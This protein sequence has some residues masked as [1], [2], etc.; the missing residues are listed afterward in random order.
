MQGILKHISF[1]LA[2]V[3]LAGLVCQTSAVLHFYLNRDS[4]AI[5]CENKDKPEMK[6][7]GKC[8]LEKKLVAQNPSEKNKTTSIPALQ[9]WLYAVEEM[10]PLKLIT[11]QILSADNFSIRH[12]CSNYCL[13]CAVAPPE[14][15]T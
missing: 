6:C 7:H 15:N 9:F 2:V 8:Q 10:V 14:L 3:F 5:N 1:L 4:I 13:D 12:F 11:P